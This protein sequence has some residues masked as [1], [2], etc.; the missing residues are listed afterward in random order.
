MTKKIEVAELKKP[1]QFHTLFNKMADF[2]ALNKRKVLLVASAVLGVIAVVVAWSTYQYYYEKNAWDQYAKIEESMFK[3]SPSE[4][5]VD[6]IKKYKILSSNYP[7]SEASLLS[8]YRL[9]NLYYNQMD[10]DAAISSYEKYLAHASDR[11]E[12]KV[13]SFSGL[14]YCYEAKKEYQK[15]LQALQQAEKIEAAKSLETFIYRD[16]GRI[17]EEMGKATEALNCYKKA[18]VQSV[19]PIFTIFIKRKIALLS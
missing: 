17:Y 15:A 4:Q 8:A 6:L 2:Y 7:D 5:K 14:A 13:L 18:L 9:A 1:D 19:D 11:N 3:A 10:Y 12:L 16:M